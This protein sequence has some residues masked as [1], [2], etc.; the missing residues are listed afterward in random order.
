MADITAEVP[1]VKIPTV[2]EMLSKAI[3]SVMNETAHTS[4]ITDSSP[5]I[6]GAG[7]KD[8]SELPSLPNGTMDTPKYNTCEDTTTTRTSSLSESTSAS[9]SDSTNV[10]KSS[11]VHNTTPELS[12]A[13][14]SDKSD[15]SG[16]H[17]NSDTDTSST[18]EDTE[19]D[20][21]NS[22][23]EKE[24]SVHYVPLDT[25][26]LELIIPREITALMLAVLFLNFMN[27]VFVT[28]GVREC[29]AKMP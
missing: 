18:E 19:A 23:S 21:E 3:D 24:M 26:N 12:E 15:T 17:E 8:I 14:T 20:D 22:N 16:V 4:S 25:K 29:L 2:E 5:F 6:V 9:E 1:T 13:D 11:T 27:F 7:V 10:E 28:S